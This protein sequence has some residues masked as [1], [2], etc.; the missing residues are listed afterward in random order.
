[1]LTQ[2]KYQEAVFECYQLLY[3]NAEPKADFR[4]LFEIHRASRTE[5]PF[6]NYVIEKDKAIEIIQWI[7][8]KYKMNTFDKKSFE[9]SIHLGCSPQ[10][11]QP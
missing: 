5:I 9:V 6:M 4:T 3:E 1:M 10:I 2:K 7:E 8:K 11:K